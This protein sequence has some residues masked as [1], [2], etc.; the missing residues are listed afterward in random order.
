MIWRS[1]GAAGAAGLRTADQ[2][3]GGG[4]TDGKDRE[5]EIKDRVLA[6][7]GSHIHHG[8]NDGSAAILKFLSLESYWN[9]EGHECQRLLHAHES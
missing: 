2:A 6:Q 8:S 7:G 1:H 9:Q 5:E 4:K 3:A